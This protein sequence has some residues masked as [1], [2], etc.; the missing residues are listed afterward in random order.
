M[1][2]ATQQNIS[3]CISKKRRKGHAKGSRLAVCCTLYF[4]L[5]IELT[6][7]YGVVACCKMKNG[8]GEWKGAFKAF[9]TI[10]T[11]RFHSDYCARTNKALTGALR[12]ALQRTVFFFVH[13]NFNKQ[14]ILAAGVRK[15][16]ATYTWIKTSFLL[17]LFSI[18][19]LLNYGN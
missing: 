16:K 18:L 4:I 9:F 3:R 7:Y 1:K 2:R 10:F 12:L 17:H 13:I 14:L 15:A 19:L 8:S 5:N 11:K 6:F